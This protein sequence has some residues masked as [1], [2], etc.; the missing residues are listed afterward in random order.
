MIKPLLARH[1]A[2]SSAFRSYGVP[3]DSAH[4][5][6]GGHKQSGIRRETHKTVLEHYQRTKICWSATAEARRVLLTAF[7]E[8]HQKKL[9]ETTEIASCEVS[10]KWMPMMPPHGP[11]GHGSGTGPVPG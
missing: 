11:Y 5:A 10:P 3:S 9:R 1:H 8:T 7:G 2:W 4:A 6:F